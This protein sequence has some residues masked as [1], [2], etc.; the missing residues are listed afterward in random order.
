MTDKSQVET[1]LKWLADYYKPNRELLILE[2]VHRL[3][4]NP[5]DSQEIINES[6]DILRAIDAFAGLTTKDAA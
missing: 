1:A 2:A 5:Q 3:E 6:A 4:A